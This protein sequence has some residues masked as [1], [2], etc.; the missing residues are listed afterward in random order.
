MVAVNRDQQGE[1][2]LQA[3]LYGALRSRLGPQ[4]RKLRIELC[5]DCCILEGE[6]PSFYVKQL[7]QIVAAHVGHFRQLDNRI[8]VASR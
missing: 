5:G 4:V 6:A 7:A 2:E 8:L 3:M 1:E